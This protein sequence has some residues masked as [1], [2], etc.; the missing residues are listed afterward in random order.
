M[1]EFKEPTEFIRA[2][3]K[4]AEETKEKGLNQLKDKQHHH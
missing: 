4:N 3:T 2:I 1:A